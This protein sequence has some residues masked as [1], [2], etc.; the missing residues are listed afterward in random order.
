MPKILGLYSVR[1]DEW[2]KLAYIHGSLEG[3]SFVNG[4]S[5]KLSAVHAGDEMPS[6]ADFV[7]VIPKDADLHGRR[8]IAIDGGECLM[9]HD[10]GVLSVA[11]PGFITVSAE[12]EV[13]RQINTAVLT[14]SDKASRGERVDT[15]GPALSDMAEAMGCCVV[16]SRT[17]PDS[18]DMIADAMREWSD[19]GDVQLILTTGGTGLSNRDVT[20]EALAS[21]ADRHIPGF[22][23]IM[24]RRSMAYTPRGFLSR[25]SAATRGSSLIITFP[26][27]ERAVRQCFDAISG[28][29]RHAV[30]ILNGWDAECG[31]HHHRH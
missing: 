6:T 5:M 12:F 14:I 24:R 2:Y 28:G 20:P 19:R 26:G 30:E 27:S 23:E 1:E 25:G 31:G 15:A 13:W 11:S 18:I 4:S 16:D 7:I 3:Q 29:L 21:V 9:L 22:G 8:Y 10:R 17:V